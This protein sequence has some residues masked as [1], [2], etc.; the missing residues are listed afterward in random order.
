MTVNFNK[1]Q[2]VNRCRYGLL[3]LS[4]LCFLCDGLIEH[5]RGLCAGCAEGLTPILRSCRR[6][7]TPLATGELCGTCLQKPPAD[8]DYACA[9]FEY[10]YPVNH[11]IQSM[12]FHSHH[13]MAWLLGQ[14]SAPAISRAAWRYGWPDLLVPVPLPAR[15]LAWRGYNQSAIIARAM[16]RHLELRVAEGLCRRQ[17]YTRPQSRLPAHKRRLNVRQVFVSDAARVQGADIAIVDDVITTASTASSLAHSLRLAGARRIMV[18]C[19]ARQNL[20]A[21]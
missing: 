7:A 4:R 5:G 14:L 10:T 8:W 16:A 20:A 9:A 12:K 17:H 6:C 15:R 21:H 19:V 13:G 11:L 2:K 3:H 1:P 18:W